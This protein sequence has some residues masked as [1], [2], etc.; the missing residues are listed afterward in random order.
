MSGR[1]KWKSLEP[2]DPDK[3]FG[4]IDAPLPLGP[5]DPDVFKHGELEN[6]LRY[7][8]RKNNYP[9]KRCALSLAV[10]VGSV[11]EDENERG[12]AH[13]LEHLAFRGTNKF[14]NY[15][16]VRF[17]ES[18]GADF[19]ADQNA[20]TSFDETVYE[21]FV[22]CDEENS[23]EEEGLESLSTLERALLVLSEFA[24]GIRATREDLDLERGTILEEWRQSRSSKSRIAVSHWQA[25]MKGSKYEHRLPIGIEKVIRNVTAEEVRAFRDKW[26]LPHNMGISLV[27]DFSE[28]MEAMEQKIRSAFSIAD[29]WGNKETMAKPSP[30]FPVNPHEAPQFLC[31]EDREATQSLVNLSFVA[32]APPPSGETWSLR[33]FKRVLVDDIFDVMMNARLFRRSHSRSMAPH[34]GSKDLQTHNNPFFVCNYS[35]DQ[36]CRTAECFTFTATCKLGGTLTCIEALLVELAR[37]RAHGFNAKEVE[38]ARKEVLSDSESAYLER[39]KRD[40]S[41]LRDEYLGTFLS[42]EAVLDA[43]TEARIQRRLLN[44]I[45]GEDCRAQARRFVSGAGMVIQCIEPPHEMARSGED[46]ASVVEKVA[47]ME[48]NH[49]I[50]PHPD[51]D[52]MLSTEDLL[53]DS[54]VAHHDW[55]NCKHEIRDHEVLGA[56]ETFLS[57]GLRVCWKRTALR[58]DQVL[59][60]AHAKGGLSQV[61]GSLGEGGDPEP[62]DLRRLQAA[63]V[64]STFASDLGHFGVEPPLLSSALAGVRC[65][66]GSAIKSFSRNVDGEV[67]P[68]DFETALRLVHLLFKTELAAGD[69]KLQVIKQ[70]VREA[71]GNQLR[72][73]FTLYSRRVRY[74]NYKSYYFKPWTL[75]DFDSIDEKDALRFFSDSF[76][77]PGQFTLVIVG[78]LDSI[79]GAENDEGLLRLL[80][81]FLGSIRVKDEAK[82]APISSM[83][84]T[85]IPFT[86]PREVHT[87]VLRARIV[88][89]ISLTQVT[90][91]VTIST[92]PWD[93]TMRDIFWLHFACNLLEMRLM[94]EMRF[95]RGEIY[96]VSVTPSFALESPAAFIPSGAIRGDVAISF[97][98]E[99]GGGPARKLIQLTLDEVQRLR[100]DQVSQDE[101]HSLL[102]VERRAY[103]V[104]LQEN[105]FWQDVITKAFDSRVFRESQNL[106]EAYLFRKTAREAVLAEI[107]PEKMT[108]Q[109][110]RVFAA[111]EEAIYTVVS[112]EPENKYWTL[113]TDCCSTLYASLVPSDLS[114]SLS[115]TAK[116]IVLGTLAATALGGT[117]AYLASTKKS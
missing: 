62:R 77:Q 71:I 58:D 92:D 29:P 70:M 12:V 53:P 5:Q 41:E 99:P 9:I 3:E 63:K 23:S 93:Q 19:G 31:Q 104:A 89:K 112:L 80:E 102:Q 48:S 30:V 39:N 109:F 72:D 20:Y 76:S 103:E 108:E 47:S 35:K 110:K 61:L 90:F 117:L 49:Q 32:R 68:G 84:V 97:S 40:S 113:L 28:S 24:F 81:K 6:G 42:R 18:I 25:T 111:R 95:T 37:V 2:L 73:P 79:P 57:N 94:K 11:F 75:E 56:R 55:T 16:L 33:E 44:E 52:H 91:P 22:P 116:Q 7:F 67:S 87:E 69:S 13:I 46:V 83:E 60:H 65:K 1:S 36:A 34:N 64:A 114:L 45:T 4:G 17:L 85:K 8:I 27:G 115:P 82:N 50:G 51:D 100:V 38:A 54:E 78:G 59:M 96:S 105:C 10:K 86:Q 26:Y 43:E 101:I 66:I 107:S 106:D 15:D 21:L 74:I 88:D 98:C 14:S